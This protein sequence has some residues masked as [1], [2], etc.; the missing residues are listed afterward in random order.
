MKIT[1]ILFITLLLGCFC[2]QQTQAQQTIVK[3]SIDSTHLLIGQQTNIR[4]EVVQAKGKFVQL[5]VFQDTIIKGVEL[6][7][8]HKPDTT[9]LG[10]TLQ[11]KQD[12]LVTSFDSAIYVLPPFM[13]IDGTDTIRSNTLGLKVSADLRW[14]V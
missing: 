11:I 10:S 5:P 3:A 6:I 4:L 7:A 2:V 13:V 14:S 12:Y 9:D 1:R 8:A